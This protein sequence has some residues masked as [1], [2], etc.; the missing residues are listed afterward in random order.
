MNSN[1]F[2][3]ATNSGQIATGLLIIAIL[4]AF[5]AWRVSDNNKTSSHSSKRHS[6]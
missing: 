4:L 2:I 3:N 5:I 1:F 6:K